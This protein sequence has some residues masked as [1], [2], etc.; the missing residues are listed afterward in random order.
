MAATQTGVEEKGITEA[1][2]NAVPP[3][4]VYELP[5]DHP[6]RRRAEAMDLTEKSR[7]A[8][9]EQ[10]SGHVIDPPA[11]DKTETV[12]AKVDEPEKAEAD[13]QIAAQEEE[14]I[15]TPEM[16][17]K[18][19]VMTKVDGVDELVPASKVLGQYQ[20]GAA[21]DVRLAD[22]TRLRSEAQAALDK[23]TKDAQERKTTATTEPEKVE[24]QA[25]V[26][27]AQAAKAKFLE[28]SDALYEGDRAKAAELFGEA[29][30][31]AMTPAPKAETT[32]VVDP[33]AMAGQIAT[34][35]EQNLSQKSALT[36]LFDD[37]PEIKAD[38]DYALLTDRAVNALL[39]NGKSMPEA[40][41]EAGEQIGEKF[42]L[43]KFAAKPAG[44]QV[45]GNAPTTQAEKLEA[46]KG[47]DNIQ[48][49]DNKAAEPGTT[50]ETAVDV[51]NEIRNS[52]PG[53]RQL[54]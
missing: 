7:Q 22:A 6:A 29:T 37:Y 9:Y 44:R 32:A 11:D 25:Q 35:V 39:T 19:K 43:G 41:A 46:K 47:L 14:L 23:A 50:V 49:N 33:E 38:P 24:A 52:R 45:K 30:A 20:K 42:K 26:Q 21:A 4:S 17:A 12:E 8:S 40:I 53:A 54:A 15:L 36:K 48:S 5:D 28:A 10:E 18:A 13:K 3:K 51:I 31:L 34:R 27:S 2:A 16:I 1:E